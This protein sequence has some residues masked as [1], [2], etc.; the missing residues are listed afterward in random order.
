MG[1]WQTRSKRKLTGGRI[2]A[3]VTKRK[4]AIGGNFLKTAL[5]KV[6]S[7]IVRT[8]GG[9]SKVKIITADFVNLTDK[10]TGKTKKVAIDS[11]VE[12]KANPHFVRQKILTKGTVVKTASGNVKITSRPTQH[13]VVNGVV[14]G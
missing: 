1:I 11:V 13:G 2:T 3:T 8:K 6:K 5:G 7:K 9:N 14:V 10:K 4:H 12:N